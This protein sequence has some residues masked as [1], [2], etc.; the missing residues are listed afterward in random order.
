LPNRGPVDPFDEEVFSFT[1]VEVD[2]AF[3]FTLSDLKALPQRTI[4]VRYPDWPREVEA[5]APLL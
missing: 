1:E 4:K 3:V 2:K 5:T